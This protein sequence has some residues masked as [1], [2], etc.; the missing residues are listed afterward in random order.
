[1]ALKGNENKEHG[2]KLKLSGSALSPDLIVG[3]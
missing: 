2:K 1:M 3:I